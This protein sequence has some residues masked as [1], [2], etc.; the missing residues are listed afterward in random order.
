MSI[1]LITT[2]FDKRKVSRIRDN[3]CLLDNKAVSSPN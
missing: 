1:A 2:G 3:E